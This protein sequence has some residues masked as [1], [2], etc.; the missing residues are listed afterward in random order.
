M[1]FERSVT[2]GI[3]SENLCV[4]AEHEQDNESKED[5]E[6]DEQLVEEDE[7]NDE[8]DEKMNVKKYLIIIQINYL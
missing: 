8:N 7:Q 6:A 4:P 5:K 1:E 3:Q 2:F